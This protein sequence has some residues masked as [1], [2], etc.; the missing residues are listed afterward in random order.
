MKL[1]LD[2]RG[3]ARSRPAADPSELDLVPAGDVRKFSPVGI[4]E[5]EQS[6]NLS[7]LLLASSGVSLRRPGARQQHFN[8]RQDGTL[9]RLVRTDQRY[10]RLVKIDRGVAE[11]AKVS[12]PDLGE[13]HGFG[14]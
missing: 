5:A 3:L 12:K 8:A 4:V 7:G 10:Q 14:G 2:P 13:H 1:R 6:Q 11:P 9:A